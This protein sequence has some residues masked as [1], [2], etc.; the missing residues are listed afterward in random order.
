MA[1][2][3][4]AET[5][6]QRQQ[7][8]RLEQSARAAWLYYVGGRTQDEIA[9]ELGVSRQVVQR[10]VSRA[11]SEK[12]IKFRIDHPI[13]SCLEQ[14]ARLIDRYGLVECEVV[15]CSAAGINPVRGIAIA[16]ATYLER[17]FARPRGATI[18]FS[19][20]RTLRAVAAETSPVEATQHRIFSLCGTMSRDGRASPFEVVLRFADLTGGE[21]FPMPL[22]VVAS[23][24]EERI[25]LQDQRPFQRL[26]QLAQTAGLFVLGIGTVGWGAPLHKDGFLVEAELHQLL[27]AGAVGEL[28]S[29]P[30]DA[31][32]V[33]IEN[34]VSE[35]MTALGPDPLPGRT[36]M[37]MAGGIEKVPAIR[38]A[39]RG[40]LVNALITDELTAAALL[41]EA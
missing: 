36:I 15:P 20:G 2:G 16:G 12:L 40:R 27:T 13:A 28:A 30:F 37:G 10:L 41:T 33:L 9:A 3:L 5:G 25:L 8:L 35:R 19:T 38:G 17:W 34:G 22:P 31:Q 39:L 23:T 11:V 14:A 1:L 7:A 29:W 21:C 26:R 4:D 32:G 18:G 6:R 24:V